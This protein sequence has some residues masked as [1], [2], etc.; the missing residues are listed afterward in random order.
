MGGNLTGP[1]ILRRP[2]RSAANEQRGRWAD[3]L[4]RRENYRLKQMNEA[5]LQMEERYIAQLERPIA[6]QEEIIEE[7]VRD[8][9]QRTAETARVLL[10]TFQNSL[11]LAREHADGS[12]HSNG[13]TRR[14][15]R[16]ALI[17]K[18][19]ISSP[20]CRARF[21]DDAAKQPPS[22]GRRSMPRWDADFI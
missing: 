3:R 13:D 1:L 7:L 5:L 14:Q 11:R 22:S 4:R 12:R 21:R 17:A 6:R 8:S 18:R 20:D 19:C 10:T 9:H 16:M 15:D 2:T